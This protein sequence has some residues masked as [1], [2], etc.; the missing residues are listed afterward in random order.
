MVCHMPWRR[1]L[2][3]PRVQIELAEELRAK[4]HTVEKF[5]LEDARRESRPP[6]LLGNSLPWFAMQVHRRILRDPAYDVI[7]AHQGTIMRSKESLGFNGHLV[8]RSV[9][10]HDFYSRYQWYADP[11]SAPG[12]RHRLGRLRERL[13]SEASQWAVDRSFDLA[14]QILAPNQAEYDFLQLNPRWGKKAH[15]TPIPISREFFVALKSVSHQSLHTHPASV[16]FVGSWHP[17]KGS[18]DWPRLAHLLSAGLP[19]LRFHFL[20]TG[21]ERTPPG[22]PRDVVWVPH[23]EPD[24]LPALLTEVDVG[25]F[26]SYLEGFGIAVVEQLAAGIPVVAYDVPGPRDI[27][28]PVD[29]SLLIPPGDVRSLTERVIALFSLHSENFAELRSR[30][31]TRAKELTWEEW[32]GPMIDYYLRTHHDGR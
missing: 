27:L 6:S 10:L 31:I 28:H 23:Y 2:G 7:D 26:P 13:V 24:E 29:P 4:G 22:L 11:H 3:G 18:R 30:S 12:L 15:V 19:E 5:S 17:R 20:G 32:V 1:H 16:A 9:G 21:I 14:D 8:V 25:V